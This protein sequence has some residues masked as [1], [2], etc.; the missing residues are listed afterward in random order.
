MA[1]NSPSSVRR[2]RVLF[3][4]AFLSP[5]ES[6]V[7]GGVQFEC[8]SLIDSPV[9]REVEWDL[10]DTTMESI[11]PPPFSRRLFLA[12]R[13]TLSFTRRVLLRRPDCCLIY[14]SSGASF[15]EKGLMVLFAGVVGV[16]TILRPVS[17][18]TVDDFRRGWFT[19]GWIRRVA[20]SAS[21][22]ACQGTRWREFYQA[23]AD[24][25]EER[26]PIVYNPVN[27]MRY[28]SVRP[29]EQSSADKALMIGW[30]ERN[31]GIWD[32]LE[33]ARRFT[34]ELEGMTFVVCGNGAEFED[35]RQRIAAAGLE[36][37]FDLRGWVGMEGKLAALSE[38]SIYL[39]LSHR[40]GLPNALLEA[41]AA[42][43]AVVAT[44]VGSVSDLVLEGRT[45]FLCEAR[46]VEDIG[47][48]ILEL[49]EHAALRSQLAA[50][51][52]ARVAETVE[53]EVVWRKWHELIM[54]AARRN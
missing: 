53:Y 18:A 54:R 26:T 50:C 36:R 5:A 19:R 13:R 14:A 33:V 20:R 24:L 11:P 1:M 30:V 8:R 28:A 29:V 31:K 44:S 21:V 3:V 9:S 40:E 42:G 39:M 48:R 4:G 2:I 23:I 6:K 22:V 35:F 38:C 10:L 46:D 45:G 25:S 16:P 49:R 34:R 27:T 52:R 7:T 41:M 43:R 37:F 32:L 15:F 17:G 47:A 51:A 12:L